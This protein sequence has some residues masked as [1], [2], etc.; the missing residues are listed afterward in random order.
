MISAMGRERLMM[1]CGRPIDSVLPKPARD[2]A[3]LFEILHRD[4]DF[5]LA[6][7]GTPLDIAGGGFGS[8]RQEYQH[9]CH[10]PGNTDPDQD[11]DKLRLPSR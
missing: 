9:F 3:L 2:P 5:R 4:A 7:I 8:I 1:F 11:M 10:G 6:E